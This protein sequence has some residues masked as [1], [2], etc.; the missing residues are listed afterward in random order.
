MSLVG[1]THSI[2]CWYHPEYHFHTQMQGNANGP[3]EIIY[4]FPRNQPNTTGDQVWEEATA[5]DKEKLDTLLVYDRKSVWRRR[6]TVVVCWT[7]CT[8]IYT[9]TQSIGS[10]RQREVGLTVLMS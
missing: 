6:E 5:S 8:Y 4:Y 7:Q 3:Q 1:T 2:T 9:Y 10:L